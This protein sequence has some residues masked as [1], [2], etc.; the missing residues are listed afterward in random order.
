MKDSVAQSM[1]WLHTWSGLLFGW[2]LFAIFLTGTLAVFDKE[3]T[4]WMQ[5]EIHP[6]TASHPNLD[7][8][9]RHLSRLAPKAELWWINLPGERSPVADIYWRQAGVTSHRVMDPRSDE[10]IVSRETRGGDFFFRFHYQLLLERPGIWIVGAA[11]MAMLAALVT[12]LI[13]HRRI[14]KDFFTFRPRSSAHRAWLDVHNVTSILVLPFHLMIT[15]TGLVI[16]WSVYMPAGLQAMYGGNREAFQAETDSRVIRKPAHEAA[17]LV[18]LTE[19]E[20]E[21]RSFWQGGQTRRVV[22]S[23]PGDRHAIVDVYRQLDDRLALVSDRVSFDGTTGERLNVRTTYAPAFL[24]QSVLSGL[25]FVQFGGPPMRWLYFLMGLAASAMIA[26]GLVLWVIKRLERHAGRAQAVG[27]RLVEVLNVTAVAGLLVATAAFFWANRLIPVEV[28]RRELW[29]LRGFFLV[30]VLCCVHSFARAGSMSAWKEQLYT[31]AFLL[32][33]LPV[34]NALTAGSHLL[35]SV[36][37][38][39]WVVAGFDL[40]A[41][42]AGAML[43]WTAWRLGHPVKE[44]SL[45]RLAPVALP[46]GQQAE[47]I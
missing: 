23:N 43:G 30:W 24:T 32:G 44:K 42:A 14:F 5:P 10:L 13:I 18:S 19:F 7:A 1:D 35:A 47:Q 17:P 12:G 40:T 22:V 8:A 16:F 21:G 28:D 27:Y 2:L 39:Q 11:A 20:Q 46:E 15:F 33:F 36:P 38:G 34:L 9:A 41:V 26:T 37:N 45:D 31:G 6:V 25:H 3:I 29:E 4:H